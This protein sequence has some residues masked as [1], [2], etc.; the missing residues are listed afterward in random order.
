MDCV[1]TI[2]FPKNEPFISAYTFI[3]Y[4][5]FIKKITLTWPI[6]HIPIFFYYNACFHVLLFICLWLKVRVALMKM[7][8]MWTQF[9]IETCQALKVC[10]YNVATCQ[11]HCGFWRYLLGHVMSNHVNM[12]WTTRFFRFNLGNCEGCSSWFAKYNYMN[13]NINER[14][15]SGGSHAL[16]V[17]CKICQQSDHI[18]GKVGIQASH[19]VVLWKVYNTCFIANNS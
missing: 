3:S 7:H 2:F 4:H 14:E 18:W 16:M 5:I 8:V 11:K 12:L 1:R 17:G 15:M 6:T 19:E 13:K 9:F 10:I